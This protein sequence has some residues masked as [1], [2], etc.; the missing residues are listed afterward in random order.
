MCTVKLFRMISDAPYKAMAAVSVFVFATAQEAQA[1]AGGKKIGDAAK[2]VTDQVDSF[3]RLVVAGAFMI[4]VIM[5]A[6][7]LMKLKQAADTQGQQVKYG[8]GLWRLAVGAGLVAV[9]T[10]TG[11][12]VNTAGMSMGE[13]GV[14]DY[15]GF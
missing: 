6:A 5:V 2:T 8:E 3:G 15:T 14:A 7:G 12:L 1:D 9:P 4:G 13:A 10:L 11:M